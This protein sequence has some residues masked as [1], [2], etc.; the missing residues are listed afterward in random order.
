MPNWCFN[1]ITVSKDALPELLSRYITKTEEGEDVF[2]FEKIV[3]IGD[4]ENWYERRFKE[5]GAVRNT[6]DTLI[7][8]SS[9]SFY[10]AWAPPMPIIIKLAELHKDIT[11]TFEYNEPGMAL[12]G[13][14]AV[15]W[16][17]G[18][19]LVLDGN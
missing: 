9:I 8:D 19:V 17:D 4:V 6:C 5:W 3:P 12:E 16:K 18:E 7:D 13:N 15:K 1:R 14:I 11:F 2:D 10:T